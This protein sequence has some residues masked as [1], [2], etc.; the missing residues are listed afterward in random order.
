MVDQPV[1]L[2]ELQ[3]L[4]VRQEMDF[5]EVQVAVVELEM[6]FVALAET[7]CVRKSDVADGSQTE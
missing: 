7:L 5:P 6:D 4:I 2:L 3:A 1:A